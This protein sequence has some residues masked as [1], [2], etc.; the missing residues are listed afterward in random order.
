MKTDIPS[1]AEILERI[2]R[3]QGSGVDKERFLANPWDQDAVLRNLEVIGEAAKRVSKYTAGRS[4]EI[5]WSRI[6]GFRDIAIHG[7]DKLDLGRVWM[8][9]EQELPKLKSNV[10]ILLTRLDFRR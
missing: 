10:R 9:V 1:L 3:I 7:Y 4:P 8:L 2:E 6:A 5:P